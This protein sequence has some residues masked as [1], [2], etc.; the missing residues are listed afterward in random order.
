MHPKNL[1]VRG[2]GNY[3][4]VGRN[5]P[6]QHLYVCERKGIA[7]HPEVASVFADAATANIDYVGILLY[8]IYFL[9]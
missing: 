9:T 8:R 2:V 5:F 3:L 1:G 7:G 4:H 6:C